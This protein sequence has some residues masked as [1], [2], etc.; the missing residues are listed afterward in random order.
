MI[1]I[2]WYIFKEPSP[3][4][5]S[6]L[7]TAALSPSAVAL[8]D[9]EHSSVQPA[10]AV[11]GITTLTQGG[12]YETVIESLH[13]VTVYVSDYSADIKRKVVDNLCSGLVNF[14]EQ[15]QVGGGGVSE[16]VGGWMGA[17]AGGRNSTSCVLA[18]PRKR[19]IAI[20]WTALRPIVVS[21]GGHAVQTMIMA[22]WVRVCEGLSA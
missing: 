15:S 22:V 5:S 18:V 4:L 10:P 17:G 6:P 2:T 14:G 16:C 19:L 21:P 11:D 7:L 13:F 20:A 3:L 9:G 12:D 1:T 8:R